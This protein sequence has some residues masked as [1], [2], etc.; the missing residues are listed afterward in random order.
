V[1]IDDSKTAKR[2]QVME[3]VATMKDSITDAYIRG[4]QYVCGIL[5]VRQHVIPL[6][7]RLYVKTGP[8]AALDLPF[9]HTTALA[10]QLIRECKAPAGVKVLVLLDAYYRRHTVV[11]ACREQKFHLAS[12]LKRHRSLCKQGWKLKA[13]RDGR[14]LCRRRR[15]DALDLAK[16]TGP[17]R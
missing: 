3:A 13:G 9:R 8:C 14:N 2:G 6:G 15:T 5:V 4:H 17:V 11:Q 7:L 16:P 12:T 1:I 10:A